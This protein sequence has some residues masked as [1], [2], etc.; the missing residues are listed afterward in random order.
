M[1]PVVAVVLGWM[2]MGEIL[3]SR[4]ILALTVILG[5]VAVINFPRISKVAVETVESMSPASAEGDE[6][7]LDNPLSQPASSA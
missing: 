5:A 3:D 6:L 2:V 1:N 4:T 7:V